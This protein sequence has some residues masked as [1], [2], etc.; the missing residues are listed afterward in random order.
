MKGT[1]FALARNRNDIDANEKLKSML[2]QVEATGA[3]FIDGKNILA[4]SIFARH[5]QAGSIT[6]EHMTAGS[7][8]GDRI[9]VGT[10][11]GDRITANTIKSNMIH[12]S[13]LDAGVIKT[14]TISAG[15]GVS[16]INMANGEFSLAGGKMGYVAATDRL[17]LGMG[18]LYMGELPIEEHN[19][20]VGNRD[21]A[22]AKKTTLTNE[23][24]QWDASYTGVYG[25]INLTGTPKTNLS[26]K[27]T[28]YGTAYT[29]IINALDAV[30]NSPTN[31]SISAFAT[32]QGTVDTMM[33]SYRTAL[34][35]LTTALT[36]ANQ[37]VADK[38]A[39]NALASAN[40]NTTNVVAETVPY[41]IVFSNENQSIP[42]DAVGVLKGSFIFGSDILVF[43]GSTRTS[44]TIG[45]VVLKDKD[46]IAVIATGGTISIN[47]TQ[48]T[49]S[50]TGKVEVLFSAGANLSAE[51]GYLDVPITVNGVVYNKRMTWNKAK[52]G[53]ASRFYNLTL[54]T[55]SLQAIPGGGYSPATIGGSTSAN[56][57]T[58]AIV[59]QSGYYLVYEQSRDSITLDV[60]NALVAAGQ[61][62]LDREYIVS[63]VA[64]PFVKRYTSSATEYN[65]SYTPNEN[66]TMVLVEVYADSG[67]T[68]LLD[69]QSAPVIYEGQ[70]A[71]GMKL[72]ATNGLVFK[73]DQFNDNKGMTNTVLTPV[74]TNITDATY[75]W[76]L[77]GSATV[78]ATT[79]TVTVG[80]SALNNVDSI[81]YL[82]EVSGTAN[83]VSVTVS[84]TV[85]VSKVKDGSDTY[86]IILT[87]E[88]INIPTAENGTSPVLTGA[89][90]NVKLY[91]GTVAKNPTLTLSSQIGGTATIDATDT[92][93]VS[94]ATVTAD[95]GYIDILVKDGATTVGTK[96]FSF[97]RSK[98]GVSG[99]SITAVDV[100]YYLST[101][102]TAQ[103]NGNWSTTAP[104]WTS[105]KYMWSRTKTTYST[106]SPTYSNPACITGT[107][108]QTGG[109]GTGITSITEEYSK[110]TSKT[111]EPTSGW[112]TSMPIWT[113][114]SYVWTRSKI[115]YSNPTNTVYTTAYCDS[116]WEA[117]NEIKVGGR[118]LVKES[119]ISVTNTSYAL[120]TLPY[121][122]KWLE[123]G[124]QY[125]IT[126]KFTLGA[127]RTSLAFY[128]SGG[129]ANPVS[130]TN[131]ERNADGICS[132]TFT[133]SYHAGRTPAEGYTQLIAYQMEQTGTTAS[134]L[135]WVKVEEGNKATDWTPAPE[136]VTAQIETKSK[137]FTSQP[138]NYA[139]GDIWKENATI[140]IA[141]TA[142]TTFNAA[143]WTL[144]GDVTSANTA[145]DTTMVGGTAAATIVS[146]AS[147]G[148]TANST[149]TANK[150]T[151]DRASSFDASGNLATTKLTGTVSDTQ[152]ASANAWN[153]AKTLVSDITTDG[154][155]TPF[156]KQTLKPEYDAILKE[157]IEAVTLATNYT[158]T[159]QSYYTNYIAAYDALYAGMNTMMTTGI[160]SNST[161]TRSTM[162][163]WFT[164]YY[165]KAAIFQRNINETAR[166]IASGAATSAATANELAK[167]MT[168]G[169]LLYKDPVFA[170][171]TNTVSVYNNS[172]NGN[173]VHTRIAKP[174]DA[175]TNSTHLIEIKNIGTASPGI[176][177]FI[178]GLSAR[179]NAKFVVRYIA[180]I[181]IGYTITTASNP[182]GDGYTDTFLTATAGT[183]KY[184][185]YIRVVQCGPTGSFTN[186]GHVYLNGA[187][188][189]AATPVVWYVARIDTYDVTDYESFAS[190]INA[191]PNTVRISGSKLHFTDQVL[192]DNAWVNNLVA[193]SI[194]A[195]KIQATELNAG[196]ITAGT[197]SADRIAAGSLSGDKITANTI[198]ATKLKIGSGAQGGYINNPRFSAWSGAYP[199][200]TVA[201][202]AGGISKVTVDTV[203]MAQFAPAAGAQQGMTLSSSYF[204]NGVDLDGMQYFALECRF[205]LTAGTN[206][207]GASFLVDIYRQ[208]NSYER[209]QLDMKEI[210]ATVTTNTWYVARKVFKLAD[211]NVAKTFKSVGGYLL[212]NWSGAGDAAKTIEF[213]SVNMFQASAQE[214]L[215]QSWTNGGTTSINGSFIATGTLS[216]DKITTGS[217]NASLITTG[218]LD[219]A[220]ITAGV[221]SAGNGKS[222]INMSTGAFS[223]GSGK[224]AY[225]GTTLSLNVDSLKITNSSV[226]T[227]TYATS[228][229]DTAKTEAISAA[230]SD[231]TS[232]ANG[233][234]TSAQ[235]YSDK[236]AHVQV[237]N[238]T[239][240]RFTDLGGLSVDTG[241]VTG[242]IIVQTPITSSYMSRVHISGYNY[243]GGQSNIDLYVSFYAYSNNSFFNY[244]FVSTGSFPIKNVLL[245]RNGS[246]VVIIIGTGTTAYSYPRVVIDE[247]ILGF[248][249]PPD[250]Y[251]SGWSASIASTYSAGYTNV[252]TLTGK[253]TFSLITAV[254]SDIN[255]LESATTALQNFT[256]TS[257]ADGIIQRAEAQ[258]I[259][260]HLN[261]LTKENADV[262]NQY[263][264]VYPNALLEGTAKTNLSSAKTGYD[265]AYSNL[266]TSINTAI[267]DNITSSAEK[268]DVDAKFGLYGT[269]IKALTKALSEA[270]VAISAKQAANA[271]A[272]AASDATS[273][274]NSVEIGGRNLLRNTS[275]PTGS[276]NLSG[277]SG[278]YSS[279]YADSIKGNVF[280][281]A[282]TGTSENY[283]FT[284]RTDKVDVSTEYTFSCDLWVNEPVSGVDLFWLSD[285]D[286][287]PQGGTGYVNVTAS[288]NVAHT[289]NIW[290][291]VTWTF[292]TKANDRTGIIRIDNNGSKVSGTNAILR[293]TN[294]KLEKGNKATDWTPAPEDVAYDIEQK[295]DSAATL[296]AINAVASS[297]ANAQSA[298]NSKLDKSSYD[299][300]INEYLDYK[301]AIASEQSDSSK[302]LQ[303][304]K[305][306]IASITNSMGDMKESWTF[307]NGTQIDATGK[308]LLLSDSAGGMNVIISNDRIS[309]FDR[310]AEVAY[311]SNKA[312]KI[313]NG[314][315]TNSAQIGAHLISPSP[316][317][318]DIT[319][320]SW[321]GN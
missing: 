195:T 102:S 315:F 34:S 1:L 58:D 277:G 91:Y 73:F 139:V 214:F 161:I 16:V 100:E 138:S 219:A 265:A 51:M 180:K 318:P 239:T 190:H 312:L 201:W 152:I 74:L 2:Y 77:N 270:L 230:A 18:T 43:R 257:F 300:F 61:V 179:A 75:A 147:A 220:R 87:N 320:V 145:K 183:G 150:G 224:I 17:Y 90:T 56:I 42:T 85:T 269:A 306:A 71:Y 271:Q 203:P 81:K 151:W 237:I 129:Y 276:E 93:K 266:V 153:N 115:I 262:I 174:A 89:N 68:N 255:D 186:G 127:D 41:S 44:G 96:R 206:P 4:D 225:D 62:A 222:T 303:D 131:A 297:A 288:S 7:I 223:F 279:I 79:P 69:Y 294:I 172:A 229:A 31:T 256:N 283:I 292:T 146:G 107:A 122:D 176:G 238:G 264:S 310:G 260:E 189:S 114:G 211:A 275:K 311:I 113:T 202:S 253:D 104:A 35:E 149:V 305:D 54:N 55:P 103:A 108:G 137:T 133:M 231:A 290:Q 198:D 140:K 21:S 98:Q 28:A 218:N 109:T 213:A 272:A 241:S 53:E 11:N 6:T 157:K 143:H 286:A 94:I 258:A 274:V 15:N 65:F 60:Y 170:Y 92:T 205:R 162:N 59:S 32:L 70:S 124:K 120:K 168:S 177:G 278:S 175:P 178:Q 83:G 39:A 37:A 221:I 210:G 148:T 248:S 29:N 33:T 192:M 119:G 215:A 280:E 46:G 317:N 72:T 49:A 141:I 64:Y 82:C 308:G 130:M 245:A 298:A 209:M 23:K 207:A 20:M 234:L 184:E 158:V 302:N 154:T 80:Y 259:A 285:T 134:T 217:L 235:T 273:K 88:S 236:V 121:G 155:L 244:D 106:G 185:E 299:N 216:A 295:A 48:P 208:D 240:K 136:D 14:G 160:A 8:K 171:G 293:V 116:S 40:Q 12:T 304:A 249:T 125:T 204:A 314:I 163:S 282:T 250:S 291:R 30:I 118:N 319:V 301:K 261:S 117:V 27:Y 254:E 123:A 197:L 142:G 26:G 52:D 13:G 128:S 67:F 84:D 243:V 199:D 228:A 181:P 268:A 169:K 57:G 50:I 99:R 126:A 19:R 76:K 284:S 289:D 36:A 188:G 97:A 78:S 247:A 182:M 296:D 166:T 263:N 45:T 252:T 25:N 267:S 3:A 5:I 101:S 233:A 9:E 287:S 242:Y 110:S 165:E 193:N 321:V 10:L 86:N 281:R 226:A 135:N 309:F 227:Q 159:G 187:A 251:V 95:A 164:N 212:A 173:V 194:V 112:Q 191:D 144:V 307:N 111:T 167:A 63:D 105:G 200:G 232:K 38:L 196:K 132:K 66:I 47:V 156:E 313:N 24:A 246:N 316:S 22:L